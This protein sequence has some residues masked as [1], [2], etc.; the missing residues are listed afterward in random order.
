MDVIVVGDIV[1]VIII[2]IIIIIFVVFVV[3]VVNWWCG[4]REIIAWQTLV[5]RVAVIIDFYIIICWRRPSRRPGAG[6]SG[7]FDTWVHDIP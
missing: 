5:R 3:K 6:L 2:L 7:L 1:V 4:G